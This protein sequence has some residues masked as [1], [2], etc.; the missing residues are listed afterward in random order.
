MLTATG[1]DDAPK[2][3][4]AVIACATG[5]IPKTTTLDITTRFNMTGLAINTSLATLRCPFIVADIFI[6]NLAETIGFS[7][8]ILYWTGV[9]VTQI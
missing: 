9:T 1:G 8:D 4:R 2:F 5:I 6:Q 3:L 7:P